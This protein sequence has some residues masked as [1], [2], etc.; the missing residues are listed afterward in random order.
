[1]VTIL[2]LDCSDARAADYTVT[3]PA[4]NH[5]I[6]FTLSNGMLYYNVSYQGNAILFDSRLSLALDG[7]GLSKGFQID[8]TRA[9][10]KNGSWIPVVGS[11]SVYPDVY[12]E[13]TIQLSETTGEKRRL[14]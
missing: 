14:E 11:K 4:G 2:M 12:N 8:S 9:D 7:E 5:A 6:G 1:M 10:S 3:S 13:C